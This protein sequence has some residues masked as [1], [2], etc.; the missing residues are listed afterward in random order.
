[1]VEEKKGAAPEKEN[2]L[3][4]CGIN[5]MHRGGGRNNIKPPCST[6]RSEE[7]VWVG[8]AE[9]E[10]LESWGEEQSLD[11]ELSHASAMGCIRGEGGEIHSLDKKATAGK[12]NRKE[13]E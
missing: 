12:D 13:S 8:A 2:N 3:R 10:G 9:G 11:W 4:C 6:A 7:G 5:N 1:V